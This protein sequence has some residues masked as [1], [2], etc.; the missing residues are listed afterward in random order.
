MKD[1][2]LHSSTAKAVKSFLNNSTNAVGIFGDKGSGKYELSQSIVCELLGVNSLSTYP[3]F[4]EIDCDKQAGIDEVRSLKNFLSIKVPGE[5]TFMRGVIIKSLERLSNAGQNALLKTLE[6]PPLDTIIVVTTENKNNLLKTTN[7]RFRWIHALNLDL[8]TLEEE[9]SAAYSQSEI[10]K[11]YYLSDGRWLQFRNI[12]EQK[13]KNQSVILS[14]E[15]KQL[16]ALSKPEKLSKIDT[17]IKS[18]DFSVKEYLVMIRKI[19]DA[20]IKIQINKEHAVRKA[21]INQLAL[22]NEAIEAA[23]YSPNEKLL[24]TNLLYNL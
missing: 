20:S 23:N 8:K 19:L 4:I 12:L 6:E 7:S 5:S 10:K 24:L 1:L 15:V 18:S 14:I 21:S 22:V 16:L 13:E 9:F 11:A 2:L 17:I 3:Y